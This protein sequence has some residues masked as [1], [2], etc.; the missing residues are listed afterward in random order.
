MNVYNVGSVPDVGQQSWDI[1]TDLQ[2]AVG[3]KLGAS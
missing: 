3:H 1:A 2:F